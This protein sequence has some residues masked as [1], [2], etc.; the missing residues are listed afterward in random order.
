MADSNVM[1]KDFVSFLEEASPDQ[2]QA[3]KNFITTH[4]MSELASFLA[5][6]TPQQHEAF[7]NFIAARPEMRAIPSGNGDIIPPAEEARERLELAQQLQG[8]IREN[9]NMPGWRF[10]ASHLSVLFVMP[11]EILRE[12]ASS[13]YVGMSTHNVHNSLQLMSD[14]VRECRSALGLNIFYVL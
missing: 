13:G 14:L 5:Q 12:A 7:Q 2:R 4:K 9:F 10:T 6:A 8:V 3:I 11:M 1:Q